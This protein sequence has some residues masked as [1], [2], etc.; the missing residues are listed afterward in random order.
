MTVTV[1]LPPGMSGEGMPEGWFGHIRHGWT[2]TVDR[3]VT[4]LASA[5]ITSG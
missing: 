1:E 2:D 3:L 4:S 5:P